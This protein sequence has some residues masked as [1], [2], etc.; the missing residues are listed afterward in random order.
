MKFFFKKKKS[1]DTNINAYENFK[2]N[3]IKEINELDNVIKSLKYKKIIML[4]ETDNDNKN[5]N[6]YLMLQNENKNLLKK[7]ENIIDLYICKICFENKPDICLIPCGHI[8]CKNCLDN[9]DECYMCRKHI[10]KKQ[11]MFLN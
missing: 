9:S 11:Q 4:K 5:Y 1:S 8:F 2:S 6:D 10:L 7:Y 3:Q